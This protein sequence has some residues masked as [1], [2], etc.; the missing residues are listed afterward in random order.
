MS[1]LPSNDPKTTILPKRRDFS[2]N[3]VGRELVVHD[4]G[5]G[6]VHF[7][8]ATASVI[9]Q[10]CDGETTLDRCEQ[11]IRD[12]F[13]LDESTDLAGDIRDAL[14]DFAERGLIEA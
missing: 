8:N 5:S 2:Y 10:C 6:R 3:T 4:S 11:R 1:V 14:V 9:W 13:A 12:A 7:L